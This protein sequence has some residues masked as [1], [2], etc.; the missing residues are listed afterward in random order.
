MRVWG[1]VSPPLQSGDCV[2]MGGGP[3]SGEVMVGLSDKGV[4]GICAVWNESV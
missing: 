1:V 4:G 3:G 2:V